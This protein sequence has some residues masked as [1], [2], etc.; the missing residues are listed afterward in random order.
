M[1]IL[2]VTELIVV[3]QIKSTFVKFKFDCCL[4]RLINLFFALR[5]LNERFI[6]LDKDGSSN[7]SD[8]VCILADI[9]KLPQKPVT[10]ACQLLLNKLTSCAP[11]ARV[12]RHLIRSH[13]L[14][15]EEPFDLAIHY[16]LNF[17]KVMCI[18]L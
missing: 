1:T 6:F 2:I 18:H 10:N 4:L 13:T 15:M 3:Q 17:T 14:P 16:D 8:T 5:R 7:S 9:T 12:M 11:T